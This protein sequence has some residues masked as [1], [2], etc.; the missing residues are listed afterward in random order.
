VYAPR[1]GVYFTGEWLFWQTREGG[2]EFAV[3]RASSS[4]GVFTDAVPTKLEF[5]WESGFRVGLGVHLPHDGWDIYASYTDFQPASSKNANGSVFPLLAFQGQVSLDNVTRAHAHRKIHFQA[6]DLEIGRAFYLAKTLAL[7]PFFGCKG[8]WIDQHSRVTYTGGDLSSGEQFKVRQHNDFKGAGLRVGL[9]SNWEWCA[10]WSF[11]GNLSGSLLVGHFDLSQDQTLPTGVKTI[12]LDSDF[13]LI[14]PQ[15]Q[16]SLGIAWDRNFCR[17][18]CH[19]GISAN[20]ETQYFW[21]QNQ[22]EWFTDTA[23][24]VYVR[25]V[26]DLSFYGISLMARLDF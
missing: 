8:A 17:D 12:D 20:F 7:R 21:G 9:G 14:N 2:L 19:F 10:G 15:A 3:E 13:N 25:P 1:G 26:N 24:P 22:S 5:D 6:A 16:L 23:A 18:R 4:P 11:V